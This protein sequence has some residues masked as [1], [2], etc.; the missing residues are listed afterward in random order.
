MCEPPPAADSSTPTRT[1]CLRSVLIV[2][3]F[4]ALLRL[5]CLGSL[6]L[7]ITNDGVGYLN[8]GAELAAGGSFAGIPAVRTPGYP[9]FLAGVFKLF[10]VGPTGVLITQHALGCLTCALVTFTAC[11]L[12]GRRWG[13]LPGILCALDPWLLAMENLALTETLAVAL[14]TLTAT[15]A[16]NG[17]RPRWPTAL[18]LGILLGHT[19]LTRPALQVIIPF[20][21]LAWLVRSYTNRRSALAGL[22][23]GTAGITVSVAPW[24]QL[25]RQRQ[26]TG[27][28]SGY[29]VTVF[30]G[31]LRFGLLDRDYP[32]NDKIRQQL[33]VFDQRKPSWQST[34]EFVAGIGGWEAEP[35]LLSKWSRTSIR[36]NLGQYFRHC[37]YALGWQLN[38]F[39]NHGPNPKFDWLNKSL[40]RMGRDG[41]NI[42]YS[43]DPAERHVDA[44]TTSGRGGPL[45]QAFAWL[46]THVIGGVPQIPLFALAVLGAVLALLRRDWGLLLILGGTLAFVVAHMLTLFPVGRYLMPMWPIWYL[47]VVT[48]P[49]QLL[50]GVRRIAPTRARPEAI[51]D[52]PPDAPTNGPS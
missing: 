30:K 12:V 34:R 18:L 41:N 11:Q 40:R 50:D 33:T 47:G 48:T 35:D 15:I 19:C 8:W 27:V 45:R 23:L 32:I 14:V 10:G 43:G 13:I 51:D 3:V 37:V 7:V 38:Y 52:R 6:P 44:F 1:R 5:W 21:G 49:M 42:W 4:A 22:L 25:N 24:L 2:T 9:L 28:A 46:G 16:L 17:R 29:G 20:F 36:K 26:V 31:L 39:P